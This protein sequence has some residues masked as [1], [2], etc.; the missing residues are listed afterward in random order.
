MGLVLDHYPEPGGLKL[1]LLI[2]ADH[3]DADGECWPSYATV[4]AR[5]CC[6][7]RQVIT[8]VQKLIDA[9]FVEV[10]EAG[11][12]RSNGKGGVN[13]SNLFRLSESLLAS[14]PRL[15]GP[16]DKSAEKLRTLHRRGEVHFTPRQG[17][18][19]ASPKPSLEPSS[20]TVRPGR[21][22]ENADAGRLPLLD[23]ATILAP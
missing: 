8:N 4:A 16:V 11:G 7:R 17:V 1:T 22:V 3:C 12:R 13:V 10:I 20:R 19:P 18:K 15:T 5:A 2:L 6:T 14:L 21:S 9:G 23:T